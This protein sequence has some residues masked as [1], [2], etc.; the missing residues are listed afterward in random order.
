MV[1]IPTLDPMSD[2][3]TYTDEVALPIGDAARRLGV[4]ISTLRNWH[5]DG[6]ITA[7]RTAGGQR[8][9]PIAEINRIRGARGNEPTD[10]GARDE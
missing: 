2:S 1:A 3:N 7:F 10:S 8:R 5:R 4:S 9:I 6:K